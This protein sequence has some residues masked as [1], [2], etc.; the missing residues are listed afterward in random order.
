M[1]VVENVTLLEN[2]GRYVTEIDGKLKVN[3]SWQ[4]SEGQCESG[5][6]K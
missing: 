5:C 4:Q 6:I 1:E 3:W 2:M